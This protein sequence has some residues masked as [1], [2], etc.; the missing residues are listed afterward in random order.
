MTAKNYVFT[1]QATGD[2]VAAWSAY[3]SGAAVFPDLFHWHDDPN[4]K[5][6]VYQIERAP[7]T[8]QLHVQG[9][10]CFKKSV[11]LTGAKNVCTFYYFM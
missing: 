2:E 4:V 5:Y 6:V 3:L 10:V 7:T 8:G 11:R 1:R 9:L